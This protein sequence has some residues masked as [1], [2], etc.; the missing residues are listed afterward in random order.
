M[1]FVSGTIGGFGN[2]V[3]FANQNN[4]NLF[5]GKPNPVMERAF[6]PQALSYP[7]GYALHQMK[8][9]VIQKTGIC[10]NKQDHLCT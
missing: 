4:V 1:G 8:K 10:C 9:K 3:H 5:S 2:A 7:F 6:T